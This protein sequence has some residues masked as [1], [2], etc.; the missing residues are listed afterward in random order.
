MTNIGVDLVNIA[1][2]QR[3]LDQ[4]GGIGKVFT[5]SELA[6]NPRSENLAGVFAAKEAFMK[7]IGRKIDWRDVWIEK[8]VSG[9]PI[10]RSIHLKSEQDVAVSVSHDGNYAVAVVLIG[11]SDGRRTSP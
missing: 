1:E 8:E 2:F 3:R 11:K 10:L 7:A 9:R 4:S 5:D 6:Q